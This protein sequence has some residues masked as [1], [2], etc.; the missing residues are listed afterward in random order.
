ML[1]RL[2]KYLTHFL[3]AQ[4]HNNIGFKWKIV[5]FHIS[6]HNTDCHC[7]S[8][9]IL[10]FFLYGFTLHTNALLH[11]SSCLILLLLI[12]LNNLKC[13]INFIT[14]NFYVSFNF[15]RPLS[16]L[17]QHFYMSK[18]REILSLGSSWHS[19]YFRDVA[20]AIVTGD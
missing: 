17:Y 19:R 11:Q 8:M 4:F 13:I 10:I 6:K 16:T 15:S 1:N 9:V 2:L 20:D 12:I 5:Y 7:N 14:V 18:L 3:R